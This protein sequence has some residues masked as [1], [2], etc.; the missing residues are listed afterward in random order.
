[1]VLQYLTDVHTGRYAQGVQHDMHR[2]AC[3][4]KRHILTRHNAG[5]DTLVTMAAC[6]LIA[7]GNLTLLGD[8]YAHLLVYSRR[9][10][11]AVFAAEHLNADNLAG[12]AV[13]YTQRAVTHL[14][15]LFT[16][17]GAQQTLLGS[18]LGFALR[19]NLAY[20][21]ITGAYLRTDADNAALVQILQCFLRNVGDLAGD[22]FLAQLG[23]TGVTIIFFYMDR[24]KDISLYQILIQ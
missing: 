6:H 1:M 5:N 14:A 2:L 23:V 22:F 17:D 9:Q 18:Q 15:C 10:V 11:V 7:F 21:D 13:R 24:G 16:K 12:L 19:S 8:V 20:Q 4:Q 3:R